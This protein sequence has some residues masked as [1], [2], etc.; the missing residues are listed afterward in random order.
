MTELC[1][2]G[3]SK[4]GESA[5]PFA[6]IMPHS[7]ASFFTGPESCNPEIWSK[8]SAASLPHHL[9]LSIETTNKTLISFNGTRVARVINL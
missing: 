7:G 2:S 5:A 3:E 8:S 4:C 1:I 9:F 6:A